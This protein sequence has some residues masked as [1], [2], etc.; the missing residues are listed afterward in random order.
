[1]KAMIL[2]AGRGERMRPLTDSVPKPLLKVAGCSLV[3]HHIKGLY[4]AGIREIVINHAWLGEQI[5]QQ[6][7]N[8]QQFGVEIQYSAE[9]TALE[10]AGG[11]RQALPLLGNEPFL[12]VNG[13]IWTDFPFTQLL[14]SAK[15]LLNYSIWAH[16]LL[17]PNPEHHLGGDFC[18]RDTDPLL[19]ESDIYPDCGTLTFSGVGIYHPK[20]FYFLDEGVQALGPV[21]RSLIREQH[22]SAEVYTGDWFDV[23]SPQRLEEINSY[24]TKKMD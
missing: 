24:L 5:E 23:G 11:I 20:I 21:L 13:D 1:M 16:L 3:E 14:M 6:L 17:V 22:V 19:Y 9:Q 12:V 7:G 15:K 8:G 10:T 18:L 4:R 2:A